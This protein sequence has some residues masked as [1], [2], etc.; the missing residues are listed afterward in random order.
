MLVGFST[1]FQ[2]QV[3]TLQRV[4]EGIGGLDIRAVVTTGPAVDP[5]SLALPSQ[6]ASV[7]IG[8]PQRVAQRS[9]RCGD[10]LRAW[11]GDPRACGGRADG[12]HADG[13]GSER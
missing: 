13:P 8:A 12:V 2:N 1:T 6:R 4:I 11:D 7:R 10:A 5:S 3:E 9:G